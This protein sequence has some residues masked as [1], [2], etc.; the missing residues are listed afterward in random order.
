MQEALPTKRID[1][2]TVNVSGY[3]H[4][5]LFAAW[6]HHNSW[7]LTNGAEAIS[8]WQ[9]ADQVIEAGVTRFPKAG[10]PPQAHTVATENTP[11]AMSY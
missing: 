3:A 10:D 5:T 1:P 4:A 7:R 9:F 8:L 11:A 2:K 6:T